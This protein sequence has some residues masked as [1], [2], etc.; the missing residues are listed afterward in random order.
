MG[1]T[2]VIAGISAAVAAAGTAASINS[3]NKQRR[4][5]AAI[6]R[7]QKQASDQQLSRQNEQLRQANQTTADTSGL[8]NDNSVNND[9]ASLTG[10]EGSPVTAGNL[11]KT[12]LLGG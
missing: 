3:S 2:A 4:Q 1:A 5:Q 7:Q 9:S 10:A 8:L 12:S 11:S 6:A